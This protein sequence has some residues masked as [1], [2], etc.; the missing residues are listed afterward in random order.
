[1]ELPSLLTN[2]APAPRSNVAMLVENS[3]A[4]AEERRDAILPPLQIAQYQA[5]KEIT[6]TDMVVRGSVVFFYDTSSRSGSSA[7]P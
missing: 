1:M 5:T 7:L 3:E 4:A 2:P 6:A